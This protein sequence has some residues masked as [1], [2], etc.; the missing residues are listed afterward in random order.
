MPIIRGYFR[1]Y[2][3]LAKRQNNGPFCS[4]ALVTVADMYKVRMIY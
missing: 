1:D 3:C 2:S 4:K